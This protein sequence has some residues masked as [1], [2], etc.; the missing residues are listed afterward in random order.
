M[1]AKPSFAMPVAFR[2]FL[3][4]ARTPTMND[5]RPIPPRIARPI[6]FV[7]NEASP[8]PAPASAPIPPALPAI[9]PE[10]ATAPRVLPMPA[11]N[12]L[13]GRPPLPTCNPSRRPNG[14]T[15]SCASPTRCRAF[16]ALRMLW[17]D[18]NHSLPRVITAPRGTAQPLCRPRTAL[19]LPSGLL[20]EPIQNA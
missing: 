15:P 7:R 8:T 20:A 1:S 11:S 5:V 4:R 16:L 10:S 14:S 13:I 19:D 17:Q 12:P 9:A 6:G 3:P 2:F 18:Q